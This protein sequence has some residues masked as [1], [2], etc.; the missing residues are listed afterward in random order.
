MIDIDDWRD[1]QIRLHGLTGTDLKATFYYDETNNIRKL[2]LRD[3]GLNVADLKV[4]VLGGVVQKGEARPLDLCP[5]RQ[6]M[7][8]QK[9]ASEIKLQHVATGSFLDLLHSTKLTVFLRWLMESD[10]LI[11][12]HDLDPFYWSVVDIIDSLLTGI[13]NPMLMLHH[14]W[15]K[16]DLAEVL[17]MDVPATMSLFH[18]HRYPGV[19]P[20]GRMLFLHE[21]IHLFDA[22]CQAIPVPNARLLRQV[23][24]AGLEL[25]EFI[26]IEG[27]TPHQLIEDFSLFY[28]SRISVF[29]Q[30]AHILDMEES[31]R[32]LL[33]AMS[34]MR[35]GLPATN[36]RFA[37]SKCESG[38]QLADIV[39]GLL[40]K[41]HTYFTKTPR[42]QVA[43]D[44]ERLT[45]T[46]AENAEL[47]R[48]CISRSHDENVAF[49][50]HVASQYDLQKI[51]V[52]LRFLDG[53]C[54]A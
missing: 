48:D 28:L 33:N 6:A 40:G 31:I 49:L 20:T 26:F 15:L 35:G 21:L 14:L 36:F 9:T 43:S 1:K 54:A 29:N 52:F 47:L 7:Q 41:M 37:D 45:G 44:R 17:R 19:V 4:F 8:I 18:R 10:L 50:N 38:I 2:Y 13:S 42:D 39:V 27:N 12:Y 16:S 46:A 3:Q 25:N 34:I 24:R 11:H 30:A 23:L 51:E 53:P 22:H 32:N 5:L